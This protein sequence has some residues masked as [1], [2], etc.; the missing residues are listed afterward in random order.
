M[1]TG[2]LSLRLRIVQDKIQDIIN[3]FEEET[4]FKL[5]ISTIDMYKV[6]LRT[7]VIVSIKVNACEELK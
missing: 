7:K 6:N 5:D 1:T 4:N 2:E 3:E